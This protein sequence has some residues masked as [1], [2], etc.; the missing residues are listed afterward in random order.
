[1][2]KRR[3]NLTYTG[4]SNEAILDFIENT[5]NHTDVAQ[6]LK[7]YLEDDIKFF[8]ELFDNYDIEFDVGDEQSTIDKDVFTIDGLEKG[9]FKYDYVVKYVM[10]IAKKFT[11]NG[12]NPKRTNFR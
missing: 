12:H 4:T 8:E 5:L 3:L 10:N 6:K 11:K 9:S 7:P 2:S 1:M